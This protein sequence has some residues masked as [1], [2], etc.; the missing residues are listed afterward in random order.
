MP[1]I[2]QNLLKANHIVELPASGK[3]AGRVNRYVGFVVVSPAADGV[4]VLEGE[5]RRVDLAVA[6]FAARDAAVL[7]DLLADRLCS[8]NVRVQRFDVR[9]R[10]RRWRAKEIV[11]Q[12]DAS[13]DR[14]RID[15][16]GC[17]RSDRRLTQQPAAAAIVERDA[18]ET[19]PLGRFDAVQPGERLVVEPRT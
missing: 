3:F 16:V 19:Q 11:Q 10:R 5:A 13:H 14:G 7:F 15:A 6:G 17:Y 18:L 4:E 8:T 2:Q 9:G 1:L 12:P